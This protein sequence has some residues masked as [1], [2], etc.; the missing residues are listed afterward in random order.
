MVFMLPIGLMIAPVGLLGS[1]G[2]LGSAGA[3]AGG[4]RASGHLAPVGGPEAEHPVSVAA[5]A[6]GIAVVAVTGA[7]VAQG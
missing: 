1:T 2:G 6:G 7:M 4:A 3:A 5:P